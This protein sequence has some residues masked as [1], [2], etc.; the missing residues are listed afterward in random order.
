MRTS[1]TDAEDKLLVQIAYEFEKEGIRVTW[2][3]VARRMRTMRPSNELRI[4][5]ASLKRTYGKSLHDFPRCFFASSNGTALLSKRRPSGGRQGS[6]TRAIQRGLIATE[7]GLEDC[8]VAGEAKML[9]VVTTAMTTQVKVV[10]CVALEGH[11]KALL[12]A[13]MARL[14]WLPSN[15]VVAVLHLAVLKLLPRLDKFSAESPLQM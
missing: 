2:S 6:G 8:E 13:V 14:E 9:C 3:Y 10:L 7:A 5:L 11:G 12:V 15:P 4:R 1:F